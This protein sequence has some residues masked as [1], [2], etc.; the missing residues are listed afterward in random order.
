MRRYDTD[1]DGKIND[2]EE[3]VGSRRIAIEYKRK[4]KALRP[5]PGDM[6]A[7]SRSTR[8]GMN[9]R[10]VD[11]MK[12]L[13]TLKKFKKALTACSENPKGKGCVSMYICSLHMLEAFFCK[14][15]FV[16]LFF[17]IDSHP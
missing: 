5:P 8:R 4:F 10:N 6:K 15:S 16:T 17:P 9:A 7:K 11:I 3:K 12:R 1:G 13:K 2:K 14:N